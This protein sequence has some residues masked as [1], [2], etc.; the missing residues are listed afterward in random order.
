MTVL[1]S[2]DAR[3]GLRLVGLPSGRASRW[4][5]AAVERGSVDE[6]PYEHGYAHFVEHLTLAD[7]ERC[8]GYARVAGAPGS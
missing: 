3:T 7:N 4:F 6:K 1:E 2:K 8:A 5:G